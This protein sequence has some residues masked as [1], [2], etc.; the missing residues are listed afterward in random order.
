V[1]NMAITP[2]DQPLPKTP[3]Y[4]INFMALRFIEPGLIANRS[5]M[6]REEGFSIFLLL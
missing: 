4:F 3:C 2:F 5:F 1:A 6:L